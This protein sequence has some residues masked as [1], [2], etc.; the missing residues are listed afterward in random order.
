[1]SD[2]RTRD[3][4]T[5]DLKRVPRFDDSNSAGLKA[6][7]VSPTPA[8]VSSAPMSSELPESPTPDGYNVYEK[9]FICSMV[10]ETVG[11]VIGDSWYS[12]QAVKKWPDVVSE[13]LVY[14]LVKIHDG[15][16]YI[17]SLLRR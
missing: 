8:T 12:P 2:Y 14:S 17:G 13:T 7:A 11:N 1:M 3:G 5:R 9:D 16:R 6:A 10:K 15:N 4:P